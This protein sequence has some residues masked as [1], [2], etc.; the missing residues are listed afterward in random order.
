MKIAVIS[1]IHGNM[2]ALNK[3]LEDIKTNECDKIFCLGDLALAGP[4]PEKTVSFVKS[5]NDWVIIQGNTDK[6]IAECTPELID[7]TKKAFLPMGF[8]LEDDVKILC[9]ENKAYL[10]N[11]PPQ[12]SLEVEGLKILLV[13]GSPRRNNENIYP[14]LPMNEIEQII[15]GVKEDL[16]LCGHTHIPAGYQADSKKTV[17]NVGSVGRPLT[18]DAKP[19]YLILSVIDGKFSVQHKFVDYDRVTAA[20]MMKNRGFEGAKDIAKMLLGNK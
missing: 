7:A 20:T 5:Q 12:Q 19:C 17:V 3:V 10:K 2:L 15:D 6:M 11:L 4:E 1:D 9:D 13:H 16:I 14:E 8:S 18:A